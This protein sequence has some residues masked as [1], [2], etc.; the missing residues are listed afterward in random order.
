MTEH[1]DRP[2]PRA[3]I[4][5]LA[6]VLCSACTDYERVL[7][8]HRQVYDEATAAYR[9]TTAVL[10]Q[11]DSEARAAELREQVFD[12]AKRRRDV[13]ARFRKLGAL[14]N[15]LQARIDREHGLP[16]TE[17]MN[18]MDAEFDR[19]DAQAWGRELLVASQ[20]AAPDKPPDETPDEVDDGP[21]IERPR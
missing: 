3:S 18:A 19:L 17:A 14:S 11:I 2:T 10:R 1:T 15:D 5:L 16:M 6:V 7:A 20:N 12:L 9:D 21:P 13:R 4:A 8:P